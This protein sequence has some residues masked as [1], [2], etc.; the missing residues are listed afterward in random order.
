MANLNHFSFEIKIPVCLGATSYGD[1]D[2]KARYLRKHDSR[3]DKLAGAFEIE[4]AQWNNVDVYPLLK[5][6]NALSH[7][8]AALSNHISE[9]HDFD[10]WQLEVYGNILESH[11]M[12]GQ[13]RGEIYYIA[14]QERKRKFDSLTN[15]LK[16]AC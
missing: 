2:V 6:L 3:I 9:L 10:L 12:V 7:I 16:T 5:S 8:Y 13:V 14:L 4:S 11:T 15:K 1:V